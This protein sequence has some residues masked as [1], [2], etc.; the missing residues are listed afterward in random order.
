LV[1]GPAGPHDSGNGIKY[2]HLLILIDGKP[3]IEQFTD[4]GITTCRRSEKN[5]DH[6][7]LIDAKLRDGD[8]LPL[9]REAARRGYHRRRRSLP[10][11]RGEKAKLKVD[12]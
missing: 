5:E 8:E 1:S 12:Y 11:L 4:P 9:R 6:L 3:V 2:E 7:H 10:F